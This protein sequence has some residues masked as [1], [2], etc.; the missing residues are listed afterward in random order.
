VR[1]FAEL[2]SASYHPLG[3]AECINRPKIEALTCIKALLKRKQKTTSN[4]KQIKGVNGLSSLPNQISPAKIQ[5]N[6]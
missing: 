4:A 3:A 6:L 5:L 2:S 1:L